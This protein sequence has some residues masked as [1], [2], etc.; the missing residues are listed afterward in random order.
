MIS[1]ED[2]EEANATRCAPATAARRTPL[3]FRAGSALWLS[4]RVD[5]CL[6]QQTDLSRE[7]IRSAICLAVYAAAFDVQLQEWWL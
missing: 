6:E 5:S 1:N 4:R 7:K 2:H 3:I